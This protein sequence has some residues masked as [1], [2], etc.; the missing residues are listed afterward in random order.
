MSTFLDGSP[1]STVTALRRSRKKCQTLRKQERRFLESVISNC[2]G[3]MRLNKTYPIH[4]WLFW[5]YLK[6]RF[7]SS[8]FAFVLFIHYSAIPKNLR[9]Y[10]DFYCMTV[11]LI[12]ITPNKKNF[13]S[14]NRPPGDNVPLSELD[15]KKYCEESEVGLAECRKLCEPPV[16]P[17]VYFH[18]DTYRSLTWLR[19]QV[20][21][22]RKLSLI[23]CLRHG[24]FNV[25]LQRLFWTLSS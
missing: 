16:A 21:S 14:G 22:L 10:L 20:F 15:C 23:S 2:K 17:C 9:K 19:A 8:F 18:S 25:H 6:K 24:I 13:C 5:N 11:S 1:A 12:M 4:S 3:M 7:C